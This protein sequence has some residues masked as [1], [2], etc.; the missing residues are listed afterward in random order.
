MSTYYPDFVV[1]GWLG[2]SAPAGTPPDIVAKMNAATQAAVNDPATADKLRALGLTPKPWTP[3]ASTPSSR[4][5]PPAG[6][7]GSRS[8]ASSRSNRP[9][10]IRNA[11]YI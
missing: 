5:T 8:P 4:K 9:Q 6:R 1:A 2:I 7:N 3:P 11:L 10:Q